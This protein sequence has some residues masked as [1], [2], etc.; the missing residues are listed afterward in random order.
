MFDKINRIKEFPQKFEYS[1]Q[2]LLK[3]ISTSTR[4]LSLINTN[5]PLITPVVC[6]CLRK[7]NLRFIKPT[8]NKIRSYG[9]LGDFLRY[10]INNQTVSNQYDVLVLDFYD[11]LEYLYDNTDKLAES[12]NI[13]RDL[14]SKAFNSTIIIVPPDVVYKLKKK[15]IDFWSCISNYTDTTKWL[16]CPV[17][18]PIVKIRIICD[19]SS[20]FIEL[21]HK[22]REKF[23]EYDNLKDDILSLSEYSSDK[24]YELFRRIVAFYN[25]TLYKA[26]YN[27]LL[28]CF[29]NKMT[30]VKVSKDHNYERFAD[31]DNLVEK[32]IEESDRK[33]YLPISLDLVDV[34]FILAE[35]YYRSGKYLDA[36]SRYETAKQILEEQWDESEINSAVITYLNINILICKYMLD[37]AHSPQ[38][39]LDHIKHKLSKC[40]SISYDYS[41]F[42]EA[43]LLLVDFA[44]QHHSYIQHLDIFNQLKG[45]SVAKLPMMDISESLDCVLLWETFI[46][47]DFYPTRINR[48]ESELMDFYYEIQKM[49]K[50]FVDDEY[51]KARKVYTHINKNLSELGYLSVQEMT[52]LIWNNIQYLHKCSKKI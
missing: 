30:S 8:L 17:T 12:I 39:L 48:E 29:V 40:K 3:Y 19:A 23:L 16:C 49:I 52:T 7:N 18:L 6:S 24:F 27:D 45:C 26:C 42:G 44:S 50:F 36:I 46:R 1:L 28:L 11:S 10:Y 21:Y 25:D 47:R 5:L 33:E 13:N 2:Y 34:Q 43:F 4:N 32:G 51:Q 15:A 35:F 31:F 20:F 9:T 38:V 22:K 41:M 14:L 37:K